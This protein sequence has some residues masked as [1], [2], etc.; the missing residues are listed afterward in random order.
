MN[1]IGILMLIVFAMSCSASKNQNQVKMN[2]ENKKITSVI[3]AFSKAGDVNNA[4]ELS[5]YLDDNYRVVMNR[6]FGSKSVSVMS[7]AEYVEKI[8]TKVFGG[9]KRVVTVEQ[10]IM[11]GTTAVAKVV[12]KGEKATFHSLMTLL[13]DASGRW[14]LVSDT[15]TVA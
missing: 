1:K 15:P 10:I 8:E 4:K 11:N 2:P 12:F 14:L 9:D 3:V 7:K 13:K 6:L 5:N